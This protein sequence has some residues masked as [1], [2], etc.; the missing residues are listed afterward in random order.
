MTINQPL[1]GRLHRGAA[2]AKADPRATWL[3]A[4]AAEG[5]FGRCA[6]FGNANSFEPPAVSSSK[7][8]QLEGS[9]PDTVPD[10]IKSPISKLQPLLVW[11]AI[12]W[13]KVQYICASELCVK[14]CAGMPSRRMAA[15]AM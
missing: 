9:G 12:I 11:C 13:A 2:F 5:N 10:P 8:A 15:V 4:E 14:R 1:R 7:L 3:G 6:P